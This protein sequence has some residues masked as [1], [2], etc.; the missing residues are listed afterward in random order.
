M[1]MLDVELVGSAGDS[2]CF[3]FDK[4]IDYLLCLEET[5]DVFRALFEFKVL[6]YGSTC[7]KG[8]KLRACVEEIQLH[9]LL[10]LAKADGYRLL[11]G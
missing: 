3:V 5:G 8:G 10:R 9:L 6:G 1:A 11:L 7:L 4:C 2:G